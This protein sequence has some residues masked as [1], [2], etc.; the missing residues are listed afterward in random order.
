MKTLAMLV[1]AIACAISGLPATASMTAMTS[2]LCAPGEFLIGVGGRSGN[3]VTAIRPVCAKWDVPTQAMGPPRN[4]PT[5]GGPGGEEGVAVCPRGS[6]VSGWEIKRVTRGQ[7]EVFLEYVAPQCRTMIP[8]HKIVEI[9]RL[10][11]GRGNLPWPS[12]GPQWYGCSPADGVATG[13]EINEGNI[14]TDIG[15]KCQKFP[16]SPGEITTIGR[17]NGSTAAAPGN[18]PTALCDRARDARRRNSPAA[19][20]LEAQCRA[21]QASQGTPPQAPPA[22]APMEPPMLPDNGGLTYDSPMIV[23]ANGQ[24]LL[25]DFCR[26]YGAN[27]GKP[28]AD[29][30]CSQQ[31]HLGASRFQIGKDVGH[32]A[33]IGNGGICN[34]STCDGFTKIQC[35][36]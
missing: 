13:M 14:V 2:E 15:L 1:V 36:P 35:N 11:F 8:P 10:Q 27:C 26:E 28:A 18:Q 33:I 32:T 24:K 17:T 25:L 6:A 5:H 30:F 12:S 20:N 29:A 16:V 23:A 31:G 19:P 4:G 34:N 22:V 7:Y 21:Y 3:L 9:G